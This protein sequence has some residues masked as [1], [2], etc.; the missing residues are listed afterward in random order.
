LNLSDRVGR[1]EERRCQNCAGWPSNR[2]VSD[3]VLEHGDGSFT[4]LTSNTPSE[5]RT[6]GFRPQVVRISLVDDWRGGRAEHTRE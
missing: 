1:L 6:C 2:F 4:S 5:C 3:D